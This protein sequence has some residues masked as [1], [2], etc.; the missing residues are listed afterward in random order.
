MS[1][2]RGA[3]ADLEHQRVTVVYD[4]TKSSYQELL[5]ALE[6][7]GFP[8]ADNWWARF[9]AN[10]YQYLDTN[11]RDNANAPP[12][13]CCSNPKGISHSRRRNCAAGCLKPSI[14]LQPRR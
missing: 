14:P 8:V 2:V 13:P 12:P 6:E 11:A 4:A 7:I 3:S 10:H 1:G 5:A 9:K